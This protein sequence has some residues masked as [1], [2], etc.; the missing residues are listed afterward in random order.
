MTRAAMLGAAGRPEEACDMLIKAYGIPVPSSGGAGVIRPAGSDLPAD[1][2]EAARYYLDHGN[3]VAARRSLDEALRRESS[4]E[5]L[6]LR[7]SIAMRAR[8]WDA[9]LRDLSS[10]AGMKGK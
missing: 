8:E 1:P 4:A 10:W 7:A 6:L 3:D 9:A 2:L 5:A